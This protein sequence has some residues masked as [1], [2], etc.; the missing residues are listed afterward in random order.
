MN[1]SSSISRCSFIGP[2]PSVPPIDRNPLYSRLV[3]AI[4]RR[5]ITLLKNLLAQK[6]FRARINDTNNYNDTML[7]LAAAQ[8][9]LEVIKILV[10]NGADISAINS[11][12]QTPLYIAVT[13]NNLPMVALLVTSETFTDTINY[14]G[15]TALHYALVSSRIHTAIIDL[16]LSRKSSI[17]TLERQF[18]MLHIAVQN[19]D[20]KIVQKIIEA[21]ANVNAGYFGQKTALHLAIEERSVPI[22]TCLL[23]AGA[24][25]HAQDSFGYTPLHVAVKANEP[26]IV[27][28]LLSKGAD[29]TIKSLSNTTA[30]D[31]VR[32]LDNQ[33]LLLI[34]LKHKLTAAKD[35][36]ES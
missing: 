30:Y 20:A 7:H 29:Y 36:N 4:N 8:E 11:S 10:D 6:E 16:L 17:E 19:R 27:E 12:R 25:M 23:N 3:S 26:L 14:D 22:T 32:D 13:K 24:D 21:G 18:T 9:D 33:E 34:F 5:D 35:T 2:T 15:K 28:L 31:L 1:S